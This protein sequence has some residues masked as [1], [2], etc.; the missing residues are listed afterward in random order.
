MSK[1]QAYVKRLSEKESLD[2]FDNFLK[3]IGEDYGFLWEGEPSL[4]KM[5]GLCNVDEFEVDSGKQIMLG[6][7]FPVGNSYE[8]KFNSLGIVKSNK[9]FSYCL[10]S[11]DDNF[12]ITNSQTVC[13]KL[14]QQF[15][16]KTKYCFDEWTKSIESQIQSIFED[17]MIEN[18]KALSSKLRA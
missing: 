12:L 14:E 8:G 10:K 11:Y 15:E 18:M 1:G 3:V 9:M 2:I 17:Q 6:N 16:Y 5:Y 4:I 7:A 13:A